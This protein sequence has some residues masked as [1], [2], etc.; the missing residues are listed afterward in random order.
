LT[1]QLAPL[2]H[3]IIGVDS[4][5]GMLDSLSAKLTGLGITNVQTKFRDQDDGSFPDGM[6]QLITSAM[7]LH[8]VPEIMPLLKA[9]HSKLEPGGWIALAD[10]E[11][12]DGRFHEDQTGVFHHGFN[13]SQLTEMLAE[14]GYSD[15][16]ITTATSVAK[17][18]REYPVFLAIARAF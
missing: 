11:E 8:H 10:L 1:L 3:K 2:L 14:T 7:T 6:F 17:G 15:I 4:S 13:R 12:E 5:L 9:L 16:C 18:G